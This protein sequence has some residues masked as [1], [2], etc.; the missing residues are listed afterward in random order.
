MR[1]QIAAILVAAVALAV[2]SS[3]AAPPLPQRAA[4]LLQGAPGEAGVATLGRIPVDPPVLRGRVIFPEGAARRTQAT[5]DDIIKGATLS[6]ID[7][8]TNR[9]VGAT[10]AR[11]DGSFDLIPPQGLVAGT[12]Y[13]LEGAKGLR[14]GNPGGDAVRLRSLVIFNG[15]SWDAI[16]TPSIVVDAL[17]SAVAITQGL[18]PGDI[19]RAGTMNKVQT[20]NGLTGLRAAPAWATHPDIELLRTAQAIRAYAGADMDPVA[21]LTAIKPVLTA[22]APNSGR[23]GDLVQIAGDGFAAY[24]GGTTVFFGAAT[25]SILVAE[26]KLLVVT[27]PNATGDVKVQT[28]QG[29]SGTLP[30]SVV[31]TGQVIIRNISPSSVIPGQ[32][33]TIYGDGFDPD[34]TKNDVFFG[35]TK[36]TPTTASAN[37]LVVGVPGSA[38]SGLLTVR[39]PVSTSNSVYFDVAYFIAAAPTT[40]LSL[41]EATLQGLF[42]AQE[43]SVYFNGVKA[44]VVSWSATEIK[45]TIPTGVTTGPISVQTAAGST[46]TG[47]IYAPKNGSLGAWAMVAGTNR[48]NNSYFGAWVTSNSLYLADHDSTVLRVSLQANGDVAGVQS[49]G[50]LGL[51][52]AH[53]V[54]NY[55]TVGNFVYFA[56]DYAGDNRRVWR[57]PIGADG[58]TGNFSVFNSLTAGSGPSDGDWGTTALYRVKNRLYGMRMDRND[59]R[60]AES[61]VAPIL[62]AA[63]NIGSW[64]GVGRLNASNG[65]L[66]GDMVL[67]GSR[68]VRLGGWND[69]Q[70]ASYTTFDASGVITNSW[71]SFSS[72]PGNNSTQNGISA[73]I[74]GNYLYIVRSE[75]N[76]W[77]RAPIQAGDSIGSWTQMPGNLPNTEYHTDRMFVRGDFAYYYGRYG[78]AKAPITD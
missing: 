33:M 71:S 28:A 7:P 45:V 75:Q 44:E 6:L 78:L 59:Y 31:S 21:A 64:S 35:F 4:G 16:S 49:V 13:L 30:F 69:N 18:F 40:G 38:T 14:N 24:P 54:K 58:S 26:P 17:T 52:R 32:T 47:P 46:I 10:V 36:V 72:V 65:Y 55:L 74:V 5:T 68:L 29:A 57:A 77:Y 12:P 20:S 1:P 48:D 70:N 63:G 22:T 2:G 51:P 53:P 62:D 66:L 11:T 15:G 73:A 50:R 34:R 76:A 42:P 37:S 8:A 67:L 3:C 19:T 25:A 43:G 61:E 60:M 9:S 27:V 39:T 41:Q 23:P 56:G